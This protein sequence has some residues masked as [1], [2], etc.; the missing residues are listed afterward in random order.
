MTKNKLAWR[1]KNLPTVNEVS[2]LV[3]DKIIT[4]E[5]AKEL[6]FNDKESQDVEVKALK[7]QVEFL[8]K[9]IDNLSKNKNSN[10]TYVPSYPTVYWYNSPTIKPSWT[11]SNAGSTGAFGTGG[12]ASAKTVA[13]YTTGTNLIN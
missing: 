2:Q 3:H 11:I 9:V 12:V 5:E 7:E 8:E 6:L 10:V 1:F 13:T 4:A